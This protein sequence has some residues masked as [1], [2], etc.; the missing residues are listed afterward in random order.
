[1]PKSSASASIPPHCPSATCCACSSR[2]T[3]RRRRDRQGN[4]VGTQYR[5]VIF[6]QTP[7]QKSDAE[8]VIGELTRDG[9]WHA[10]IVTEIADA[11]PFYPAERY[12]QEYFARNRQTAVLRG[13][14]RAQGRQVPQAVHR[15]AEAL[16]S[17]PA[18]EPAAAGEAAPTDQNTGAIPSVDPTAPNNSGTAN[19]EALMIDMRTPAASPI[20]PAGAMLCSSAI[21]IGCALPSA[22]PSANDR[23]ISAPALARTGTAHRW[24]RQ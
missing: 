17:G 19:V 7:E 8:A 20:R 2:F 21:T 18:R 15:P 5:S 4:D 11:A 22:S 10:P 12:H 1:M 9:I 16:G 23:T 14:R 3:I 13:R 24:R 6:C